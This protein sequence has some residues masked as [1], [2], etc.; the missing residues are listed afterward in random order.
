MSREKCKSCPATAPTSTL[1]GAERHGLCRSSKASAPPR[2]RPSPAPGDSHKRLRL[3]GPLE[4]T[5]SKPLPNRGPGAAARPASQNRLS[6]AIFLP[7]SVSFV[8]LR[9]CHL[10][11]NHPPEAPGAQNDAGG[12]SFLHLFLTR[13]TSPREQLELHGHGAETPAGGCSA[14]PSL[15]FLPAALCLDK[16]IHNHLMVFPF[17]LLL[18][19]SR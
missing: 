16:Q 3:K 1:P 7:P 14:A 13:R 17:I 2:P 10:F 19:I 6:W 11:W 18:I 12:D 8:F 9:V 5:A 15:P 4:V